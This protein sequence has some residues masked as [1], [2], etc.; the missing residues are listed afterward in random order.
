MAGLT[1]ECLDLRCLDMK[2]GLDPVLAVHSLTA[3][4]LF[5]TSVREKYKQY[6][7][8]SPEYAKY[9]QYVENDKYDTYDKYDKYDTYNKYEKY[10]TNMKTVFGIWT[11]LI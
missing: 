9:T 11:P 2:A 3:Q 6:S 8:L 4:S 1:Q 10:M 7:E 5:E